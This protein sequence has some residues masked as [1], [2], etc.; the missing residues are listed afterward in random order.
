MINRKRY[1]LFVSLVFLFV[2]ELNAQKI[3]AVNLKELNKREDTLK[4][5]SRNVSLAETPEARFHANDSFVRKF[6]Q[7][8]NEVPSRF[9][10]TVAAVRDQKEKQAA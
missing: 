1:Y 9:V 5:I 6:V 3:T 2:V 10:R 7:T 4:S 8:L